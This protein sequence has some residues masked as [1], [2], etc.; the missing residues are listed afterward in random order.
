MFH[1]FIWD[2][3]FLTLLH[4]APSLSVWASRGHASPATAAMSSTQRRGRPG[5]RF[6]PCEYQ[7][8]TLSLHLSLIKNSYICRSIICQKL[9]HPNWTS[10]LVLLERSGCGA[11][12]KLRI[13][14]FIGITR[15]F[16]ALTYEDL[17]QV[18]KELFTEF[19]IKIMLRLNL[20]TIK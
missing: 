20:M 18:Y 15:I 7:C 9:V 5:R 2:V 12:R 14:F 3:H 16:L 4:L 8:S 6:S 11:Y 1:F 17:T 10:R 19:I 13:S